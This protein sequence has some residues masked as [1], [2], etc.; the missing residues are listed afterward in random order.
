MLI[1]F[2]E[3]SWGKNL[4][5]IFG[6]IILVCVRQGEM[7]PICIR[8]VGAMMSRFFCTQSM[9]FCPLRETRSTNSKSSK[10]L[11][12]K[13]WQHFPLSS[14]PIERME[15]LQK[16]LLQ[17]SCAQKLQSRKPEKVL[18][19]KWAELNF[20]LFCKPRFA[21]NWKAGES[22]SAEMDRI[23]PLI[24]SLK[25]QSRI[26]GEK[27]VWKKSTEFPLGVNQNCSPNQEKIIGH[28]EKWTAFPL[29]ANPK[30]QSRKQ[31]K[32]FQ[33]NGQDFP[34]AWTQNCK[35]KYQETILSEKWAAFPLFANQK[36]AKS[37]TR[38]YPSRKWGRLSP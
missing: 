27:L 5:I 19:E 7:L 21:Q 37:Q 18:P 24:I 23:S 3:Y 38:K 16:V 17:K 22:L 9:L 14:T 13:N 12:Q 10:S 35:V 6:W 8:I 28:P 1:F 32:I 20:P 29:F 36:I 2:G 34:L 30:L 26:A 31:E 33:K 4:R 11:S 15:E 25:L